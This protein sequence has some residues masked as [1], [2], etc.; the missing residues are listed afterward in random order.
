M[1][2][3]I[4]LIVHFLSLKVGGTSTRNI[5]DRALAIILH[6]LR[7]LLSIEPVV[8]TV[9][10]HPCHKPVHLL[11]HV[12]VLGFSG[13]QLTVSV[14]KK[15]SLVLVSLD[16]VKMPLL[17]S[18]QGLNLFV[19]LSDAVSCLN[20]HEIGVGMDLAHVCQAGTLLQ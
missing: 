12:E 10:F 8:V 5:N 1:L 6:D 2:S 7:V 16:H 4:F 17:S 3:F 14:N 15:L 20:E 11:L 9:P 18:S 13:L 19:L